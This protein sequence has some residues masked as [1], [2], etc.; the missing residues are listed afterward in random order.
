MACEGHTGVILGVAALEDLGRYVRV[1][2]P[3]PRIGRETRSWVEAF[4]WLD[5]A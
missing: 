2:T 4:N 1:C 3:V 5:P